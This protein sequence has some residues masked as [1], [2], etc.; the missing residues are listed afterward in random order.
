MTKQRQ[1]EDLD[2][3]GPAT[4]GDFEVLGIRSVSQLARCSPDVLYK[5]LCVLTQTRHDPCV[6]DVFACAIAQARDPKL[7]SEQRRWWYWTKV[8]KAKN[9]L[10]T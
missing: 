4:L 9:P 6:W 7:P 1:L 8:R 10:P 2:S 3:V 5:R